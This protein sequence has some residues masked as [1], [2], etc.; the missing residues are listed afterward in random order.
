MPNC[1][2]CPKGA[3]VKFDHC[4]STPD[5]VDVGSLVDFPR[6]HCGQNPISVP[7]CID[8]VESYT[9]S[10]VYVFRGTADEE[11]K[12]GA[13]ENTVALLAQMLPDP[14]RARSYVFFPRQFQACE[15]VLEPE[16]PTRGMKIWPQGQKSAN[17]S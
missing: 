4:K 1:D 5:I 10:K 13:V 6:R 2:G 3:T 14:F 15:S 17:S 11:Y 7:E 8:A 12:F 9:P 16:S